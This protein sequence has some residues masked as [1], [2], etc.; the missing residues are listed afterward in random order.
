MDRRNYRGNMGRDGG[1]GR[2]SMPPYRP[3]NPVCEDVHEDC[4]NEDCERAICEG[5]FDRFPLGMTYVPWQQFR[6]LYE[7]EFVAIERGTLFKELDLEWYGR[8]CK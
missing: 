4:T 5:D 8:S 7:N 2:R 1:Y 6:C 3:S